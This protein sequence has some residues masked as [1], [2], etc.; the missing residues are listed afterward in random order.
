MGSALCNHLYG[1]AVNSL[2]VAWERRCGHAHRTQHQSAPGHSCN[3]GKVRLTAQSGSPLL[4]PFAVGNL[5][6]VYTTAYTRHVSDEP[7]AVSAWSLTLTLARFWQRM[8]KHGADRPPWLLCRNFLKSYG[9]WWFPPMVLQSAAFILSA[10]WG[11]L[12]FT[13]YWLTSHHTRQHG[14]EVRPPLY[15]VLIRPCCRSA[16][17]A[18]VPLC[19]LQ[20]LLI[21]LGIDNRCRTVLGL[22]RVLR[23][24][25]VLM[26]LAGEPD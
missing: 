23:R 25:T 21:I 17:P 16:E 8:P 10:A 20:I 1:L 9:V 3:N 5:R 6:L 12:I 18:A 26:K 22:F 2:P 11:V 7:P 24:S 4:Y 19:I 15:A 13:L 14:T